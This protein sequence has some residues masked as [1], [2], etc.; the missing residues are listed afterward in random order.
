MSWVSSSSEGS[1]SDEGIAVNERRSPLFRTKEA[2]EYCGVPETSFR[3][4]AL[5]CIRVGVIR[6]YERADLDDWLRRQEESKRFRPLIDVRREVGVDRMVAAW[7]ERPLG[8]VYFVQSVSG[9]PIK[10]GTSRD[11]AA[12]MR[13]LEAAAGSLLTVLTVIPGGRSAEACLHR[14]FAADRVHGEW[15]HPSVPLLALIE[16]LKG[17]VA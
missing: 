15:F 2:A 9:G 5:R 3:R 8:Y 14:Q 11:V 1:P 12:R 7:R 17:G 16:E 10:I 13:A 4:L 6:L